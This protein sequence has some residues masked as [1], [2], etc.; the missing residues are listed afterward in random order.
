MTKDKF[1]NIMLT[2]L[3][4]VCLVLV[5]RLWYG[6]FPFRG[7]VPANTYVGA[8]SVNPRDEPSAHLMLTSARLVITQ[9]GEEHFVYGNLA[10]HRGWELIYQ[11]I[12]PLIEGGS[13]I[14]YNAE[15]PA[16]NSIAIKYNFSM[17]SNF[18]REY[19]GRRPGFL[20]SHFEDFES[21]YVAPG[22]DGLN[23]IFASKNSGGNF[24]FT[25]N[26]AALRNQIAEFILEYEARTSCSYT[27]RNQIATLSLGDVNPHVSFLFPNPAA[28]QQANINGVFTFY[29]NRRVARFFPNHI[30]EF[31]NLPNPGPYGDFTTSLLIAFD[32][33]REDNLGNDIILSQYRHFPATGIWNFYFDYAVTSGSVTKDEYPLK[34]R[35]QRRDVIFYRRLMQDF[36]EEDSHEY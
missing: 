15:I 14:S 18:F 22:Q 21:L 25:L 23:F 3:S 28:I 8:A 27:S 2:A 31:N 10:S 1:K 19:F 7:I 34:V 12:S 35:V 29:D 13:F 24:M 11:S 36:F 26:N 9:N 6:E 20:S 4:L 30:L 32:M 5:L 33:I 17:P 16:T